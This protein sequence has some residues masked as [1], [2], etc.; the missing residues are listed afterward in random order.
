[1]PMDKA[2]WTTMLAKWAESLVITMLFIVLGMILHDPL[3]LNSPFPWIWFAPVMIGVQYGLWPSQASI[4]LLLGVYL[5]PDPSPLLATQFQLFLLGGFTLTIICAIFQ[6]RWAK[7][8]DETQGLAQY[9]QKR[10]QSTADAY[11]VVCLAYQRIEQQYIIKP[12][13]LRSSLGELR[14]MIARRT[15]DADQD[16]FGRFLNIL[17]LQCSFEIAAIFPVKNGKIKPT[18]IASIGVTKP[19]KDDNYL[20]EEC[21]ETS[22]ISYIKTDDVLQDNFGQYLLA[23]PFLNQDNQI[24]SILLIESMPFLSLNDENIGIIDVLIRY[25]TAGTAT[26][27]SALILNAYPEC[28]VNFANELDR[29][30]QLQKKT[31]QDS[32]VIALHLLPHPHQD[33]YLFAL[34]KEKRGLDTSWE[35]TKNDRKIFMLIMPMTS[36]AGVESYK[37]RINQMLTKEFETV[38]NQ[39]LIK[40]KTYQISAFADPT[41]LI[42]DLI[43]IT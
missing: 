30:S 15:E 32:A 7:K 12:V 6:S 28:S 33:D 29:L 37:I 20:I 18:S 4:L 35:I 31:C 10:I 21:I 22:A 2:A 16:I 19:P 43:N 34:L 38:L 11:R 9:L 1:M 25:F 24:E 41:H 13:S 8:I 26:K 14:E 39:G 42:R 40:F 3:S 5:Y 17:A 23:A 36:R 27:N